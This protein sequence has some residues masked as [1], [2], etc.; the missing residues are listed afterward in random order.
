M[1]LGVKLMRGAEQG[2]HNDARK[3]ACVYRDGLQIALLAMRPLR[4]K[5]FAEMGLQHHLMRVGEG[6]RIAT[7]RAL[8][9]QVPA[10]SYG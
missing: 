3:N 2:V 5:N 4:R 7:P 9:K 6:W 10:T 8:S 1:E